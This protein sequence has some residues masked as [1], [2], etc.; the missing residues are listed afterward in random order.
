MFFN[1]LAAL[2]FRLSYWQ[3]RLASVRTVTK[4][5]LDFRNTQT[6]RYVTITRPRNRKQIQRE[7]NGIANS[8]PKQQ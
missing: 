1:I 8:A 3:C 2:F 4:Q 6:Y 7:V 5:T